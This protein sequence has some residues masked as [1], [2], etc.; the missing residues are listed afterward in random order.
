MYFPFPPTKFYE[1]KPPLVLCRPLLGNA[2]KRTR[3]HSSESNA[4]IEELLKTVFFVVVH[5]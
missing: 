2:Y 3:L 5:V 1:T 4:T